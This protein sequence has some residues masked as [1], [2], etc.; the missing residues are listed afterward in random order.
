MD[1]YIPSLH[2]NLAHLIA[3]RPPTVKR[4]LASSAPAMP[5]TETDTFLAQQ[6][7][8]RDIP[9]GRAGTSTTVQT[10]AQAARQAAADPVFRKWAKDFTTIQDAE[11]WVRDHFVYRD[12]R[13]EVYRTPKFMLEDM[14]RV[15]GDRVIGLEGDCDDVAG[16]LAA[17]SKTL[18]YP[19]RLVAI[20]YDPSNP[21]FEHVFAE[22]QDA[23]QWLTLDPTIEAGS[24]IRSV[25]DMVVNV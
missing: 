11:A 13:E 10:I 2:A 8:W 24:T 23:G 19:T 25:E 15:A 18:Q 5:P 4:N 14:G 9:P 21:D 16:F 6:I 17:I 22:A 3:L 12:E 20:R 1:S 7:A